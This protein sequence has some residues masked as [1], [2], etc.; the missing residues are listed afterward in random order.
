MGTEQLQ[1]LVNIV[2]QTFDEYIKRQ[3]SLNLPA[4]REEV[5]GFRAGVMTLAQVII[6]KEKTNE[7]DE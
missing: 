1:E 2:M 3:Q 7:K 5:Q 6:K 4:S